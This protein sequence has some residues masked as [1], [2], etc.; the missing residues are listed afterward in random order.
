MSK[1]KAIIVFN[2]VKLNTTVDI[3]IPLD[4]TATELV[5]GLNSAYDLGI[6]TTDIKNC[7]MKAE[8]PI[9][10]LRGNKTLAQYGIRNGSIINYTE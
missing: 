2:N 1:D 7:Y 6:D 9:A 8:N 10:L 4:I 5:I 3:E